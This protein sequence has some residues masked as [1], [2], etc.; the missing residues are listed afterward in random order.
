MG[1]SRVDAMIK[2]VH[3]YPDGTKARG[4]EVKDKRRDKYYQLARALV[5]KYNDHHNLVG[6]GTLSSLCPAKRA[7]LC[8]IVSPIHVTNC[9]H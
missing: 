2:R 8:L 6:V 9:N 4:S 5:H 3:Y 1:L 7:V